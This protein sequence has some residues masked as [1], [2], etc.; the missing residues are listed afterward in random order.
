MNRKALF[1]IRADRAIDIEQA[2]AFCK[3]RKHAFV[4]T[5]LREAASVSALLADAKAPIV[6]EVPVNPNSPGWDLGPNPDILDD[7]INLPTEL[8]SL[9]MAITG[10]EGAPHGELMTYAALARS[11]GL[12]YQKALAS[13]TSDAARVLGVSARVG[14]IGAGRDADFLVLGGEP[15]EPGTSIL[16][17]YVNGRLKFDAARVSDDRL[18][19]RAGRVWTGD[20][21][22]ENGSVLVEKGRIT[23]V[24][25]STP[26]PP[27]TR[28]IDAGMD[29]VVTPGFIDARGHLGCEGDRS[30]AA[31]DASI[32]KTVFYATPEFERVSRA[33][34]TT[35]LTSPYR[36]G[37]NGARIS[38]IHTAGDNREDL[39]VKDAAGLL[40]SL[41]GQEAEAAAN[42]LR[43]ALA[44]G[45]KYDEAWKKYEKELAEFKDKGA[46][47][48]EEKK[49]PEPKP[50]DAPKEK[51]P[52]D[53][54]TG[55]WEGEI[56][57][58]PLPEPQQFLAKMKLTG[59]EVVG[60]IETMFG[61]GETIGI[62][63]TFR[64]KHLSLEIEVEIPIGKAMLELDVDRDDH[65]TGFLDIA[66]RFRFDVEAHRTEKTVPEIKISR[67]KKKKGDG[68]PEAPKK[69]EALE[70]Y[71]DLFAGRIAI[72]LDVDTR[73]VIEAILPI[74]A[75]EHKVPFV[76]LNADEGIKVAELISKAGAGVILKPKPI[77]TVNRR[78][79]VQAVDLSRASLPVA[80]QSDA[81]DAA[82]QL[83]L[84]ATFAVERG[85]DAT[86][87]LKALTGDAAKMMKCDDLVGYL[88]PG[89]RG[90][91]LIFDGP[92]LAPASR[93]MRV[94]V[95][96]KEVRR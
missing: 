57:G 60:S 34:V 2:V 52:E 91:L 72:V 19:V 81:E 44:A 29:A 77:E 28:I 40:L 50:D 7:E 63:G 22:I 13:V 71:R 25:E 27:Y 12:P 90:D 55:T 69:D 58:G 64:D 9:T 8:H 39:V 59:E 83:P 23:A 93:L 15:L 24:G 48:P 17:T 79:V 14:S 76:L 33:G 37:G 85:M 4:I 31:A 21:W 53:P 61:G 78:E 36:P 86:A 38:A 11:A 84:R 20:H 6:Y 41:R 56:S 26:I 74:F 43:S 3:A 96:G 70:P 75:K 89:C 5:G 49:E 67:K 88:K 45:Q 35:V 92:P 16:R 1:R 80:F 46:A 18:V 94:L 32:A 10:P 73:Q 65:I 51:P 82:R 68:G 66:G 62:R 87:A 54:V 95:D 30:S 42:R 47:K